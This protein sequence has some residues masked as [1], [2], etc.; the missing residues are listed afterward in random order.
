MIEKTT[1]D[2][3]KWWEP[4]RLWFNFAV[5]LSGVLAILLTGEFEFIIFDIIGI[6]IWGVIANILFSTGILVEILDDYYFKSKLK[7][8]NFRWLFYI[9][10]TILYCIVTFGY[11][12]LYYSPFADF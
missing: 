12:V 6:F 8:F 4:K 1:N 2:I 7:L 5:G 10:G 9:V 11:A 3:L